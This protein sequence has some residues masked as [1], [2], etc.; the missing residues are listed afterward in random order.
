MII[1]KVLLEDAEKYLQMLKTLDEQTNFMM[2]EPG[3]RKTTLEEQKNIIKNNNE[4]GNPMFLME[5][6]GEIV[7]FLEGVR[8]KYNRVNHSLYIALGILKNYRGKGRGRALM[9]KIDEWSQ[10]NDIK[11]VE[12]TVI[13]SNEKAVNLYK[14]VGF[15][16]EGIKE[17]SL[18]IRDK[19][20][21]EYYMAKIY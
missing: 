21:D 9:S 1:R 5:V 17:S 20:V 3:E 2:F 8:D 4:N 14:Y 16:I 11:R 13:C 6:E 19:F 15:K 18:K 10:N 7:G 12:L